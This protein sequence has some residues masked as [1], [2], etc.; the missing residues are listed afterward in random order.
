[1]R[2]E[3]GGGGEDAI[4]FLHR[5]YGGLCSGSEHMGGRGALNQCQGSPGGLTVQTLPVTTVAA[6][7]GRARPETHS[8]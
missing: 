6:A 1:M 2:E 5:Y 4:N 3:R 8:G 7:L